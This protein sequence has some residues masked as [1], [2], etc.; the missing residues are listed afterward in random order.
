MLFID[1]LTQMNADPNP[2]PDHIT[3]HSINKIYG[4]SVFKIVNEDELVL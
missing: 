4:S 3:S 1:P 2:D